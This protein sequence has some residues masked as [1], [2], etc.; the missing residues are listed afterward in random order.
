MIKTNFL[1]IYYKKFCKILSQSSKEFAGRSYAKFNKDFRDISKP[2]LIFCKQ[3]KKKK[4]TTEEWHY[5]LNS[6]KELKV[7]NRCVLGQ[8]LRPVNLFFTSIHFNKLK[9]SHVGKR[10][11]KFAFSIPLN[12]A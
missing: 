3:E 1:K 10:L 11:T 5:F 6:A 8:N 7:K 9:S 12:T 2:F 4:T